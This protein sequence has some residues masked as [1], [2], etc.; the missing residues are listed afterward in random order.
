M[1][2]TVLPQAAPRSNCSPN[3]SEI[4]RYRISFFMEIDLSSQCLFLIPN[5]YDPLP[6][7]QLPEQE[8]SLSFSAAEPTVRAKQYLHMGEGKRSELTSNRVQGRQPEEGAGRYKGEHNVAGSG[9]RRK[10]K[11][12]NLSTFIG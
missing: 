7:I 1:E 6:A 12:R 10:Y 3:Y 9:K 2:G 11:H 4:I 5:V 8:L